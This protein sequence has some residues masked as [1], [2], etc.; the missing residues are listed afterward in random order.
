[1]CDLLGE[2]RI[3]QKSQENRQKGQTRT[4]ERKSVQEPEAKAKKSELSVKVD[5]SSDQ[6]QDGKGK[7]VTQALKG[8]SDKREAHVAGMKAQK[9]VGFYS[10]IT[11]AANTNVTS[12][13][14]QLGN[15]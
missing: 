4:Q 5:Y 1:M 8:H 11:Q 14:Y 13:D 2:V 3:Y 12:T 9:N 7:S 10:T 15:P 6:E